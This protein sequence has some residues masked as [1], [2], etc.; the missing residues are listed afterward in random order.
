MTNRISRHAH[1]FVLLRPNNI[2][3]FVIIFF[4]ASKVSPPPPGHPLYV[5]RTRNS[6]DKKSSAAQF[7]KRPKKKMRFREFS[8][9]T[10]KTPVLSSGSNLTYRVTQNV[11]TGCMV[12]YVVSRY[13]SG[14][15]VLKVYTDCTTT[16]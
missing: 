13:V 15:I 7:K 16:P 3:V 6:S 12:Y 4:D 10:R 9:S 11:V 2:S 5:F 1:V 14:G 8:L